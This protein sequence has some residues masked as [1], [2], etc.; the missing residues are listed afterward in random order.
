MAEADLVPTEA[1]RRP[2]RL[3]GILFVIWCC[4]V[5]NAAPGAIGQGWKARPGSLWSFRVIDPLIP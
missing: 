4:A 3:A 5:N 1:P 2:E